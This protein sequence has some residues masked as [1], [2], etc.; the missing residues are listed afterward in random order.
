MLPCKINIQVFSGSSLYL[1]YT[2]MAF[3]KQVKNISLITKAS[4]ILALFIA[5]SLAGVISSVIVSEEI[6]DNAAKVN[7]AGSLRM[8]AARV[9]VIQPIT[10]GRTEVTAFQQQLNK[11]RASTL[12]HVKTDK[13]FAL[14][15]KHVDKRWLTIK[16][17]TA[18][19]GEHQLF[20]IEL[21]NIVTYFQ[22]ETENNIRKLRIIQ[23]LGLFMM[24]FISYIVIYKSQK[25]LI[26][27]FRQL[28]HVA[29]E[30]GQKNFTP[31]ADAQASGE[32]GL[33]AISLNEM[34][35]Q[36][37]LTYQEYEQTAAYK[38]AELEQTNRSLSMLYLSARTLSSS[39]TTSDLKVL[40][41]ELE[42][43]LKF[44]AISI[45]LVDQSLTTENT[46][47]KSHLTGQRRYPIKKYGQSFG[48]LTWEL[49]KNLTPEPWQ[50]DL[51][52]AISNL[53]AT[54]SDL[55]HK[56]R[57]ESR[58]EILEERAVIARELHDSLAQSLSYLKLQISLLNKQHEKGLSQEHISQT[59][60]E[61]SSSTNLAYKQLREILTTFRLK[62]DNDSIENSIQETVNEFSEKCHHPIELNQQLN[63]N[64]LKPH[65][66]IHLL[67]IIREALSNTHKHA[68]ASYAE[69]SIL[70]NENEIQVEINDNGR[71]YSEALS[72]EGHFGVK[73]MQE[74][75]KSLDGVL[76]IQQNTPHGTRVSLCFKITPEN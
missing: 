2:N 15:L 19:T 35:K 5:L 63:S 27:P 68:H 22:H 74:R 1:S 54:S 42:T 59:I 73:I 58:L 43:T 71:G 69:V 41:S 23:Y 51:L 38:N 48:W 39:E 44:G 70:T 14:L 9:Q 7:L 6:N 56:R 28:V 21:D 20:A 65:Q 24:I 46:P 18:S 31:Q 75:A 34:S 57:T 76:L 62:L 30:A 36:L 33:L 66:E 47:A 29:T 52:D 64:A 50:N 37:S 67:Q 26:T 60:G 49:P 55:A 11:L 16:E 53:I 8:L 17:R 25:S 32:L 12:L 13:A 10:S 45:N 40:L 4:Q 61:I 72:K 3:K